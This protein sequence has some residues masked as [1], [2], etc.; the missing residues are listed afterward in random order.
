[1]DPDHCKNVH[2]TNCH[3]ECA[4]DCIVFKNT[5]KENDLGS[6][7]NITVSNCTLRSSSAAI[8]FGTESENLFRNINITNCN[9]Y[10]TNRAIDLQLR[11]KGSIEN[12][13]IS[14]INVETKLHSTE[15]FWG[16]A[17]VIY[18]TALRRNEDTKVGHIKNITFEN[19]NASSENGIVICGEEDNISDISFRNISV[20]LEK[21]TDWE[22]GLLDLRPCIENGLSND[23]LKLLYVKNAKNITYE[24]MRWDA[25]DEMKDLLS[26][27][28]LERLSQEN[29]NR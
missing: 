19:I 16:K 8:K 22:K 27:H 2:I 14:N 23:G 9:I 6:C 17:E 26:A 11:D 18:V 1:I 4:D 3:I 21:K 28:D 12:V 15:H 13:L 7:E 24:N 5:L 10:E 20:K 29:E 25:D